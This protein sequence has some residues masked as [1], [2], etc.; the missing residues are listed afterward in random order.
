[1]KPKIFALIILGLIT[2]KAQGQHDIDKTFFN[3]LKRDALI[4]T[5]GL[6]KSD[7]EIIDYVADFVKVNGMVN[8][9]SKLFSIEVS[10]ILDYEIGEIQTKNNSFSVMFLKRKDAAAGPEIEFLVIYKKTEFISQ[11]ASIDQARTKWME[12]C[13]S[14]QANELVINL[15]TTNAYYYNRG[16]LLQGTNSIA[17][18]YSYMNNPAYTLKLTPKHVAFVTSTIVFE[19]GQCSGSY[20]N[21][22]ML[23]WEKQPDG[24]WQVLMDTND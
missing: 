6:V 14:H 21:P 7:N 11:H 8:S 13:N 16:R 9:Y 23:L 17:S 12:L 1:M 20:P 4:L 24:T 5:D 15:Y 3:H 18:E 10:S 2:I 19:I 22:Y